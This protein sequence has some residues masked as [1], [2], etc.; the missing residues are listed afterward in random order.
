M[1]QILDKYNVSYEKL[2]PIE[3]KWLMSRVNALQQGQISL[4]N[5]RE[6]VEGMKH[7]AEQELMLKKDAP[8]GFL[9]L[10]GLFIPLVGIIRKWYQDQEEIELKA[11]IRVLISMEQLLMSPE[12]RQREIESVVASIADAKG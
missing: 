11:R 6:A 8:T 12:R 10:L 4:E 3:R 1:D 5:I 7:Q 9:S 2:N